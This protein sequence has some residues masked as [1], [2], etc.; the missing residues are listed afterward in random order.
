[1]HLDSYLAR[2]GYQGAVTPTLETLRKLHRAHLLA[3][4]FENLDIVP[5][6]RPISLELAATYH[7]IVEK[8]RGGFCFEQNGL[9]AWALQQLGFEVHL[10]Q[11]EV[12]HDDGGYGQPFNHLALLVHLEEAWLTD[13]GFGDHFIEPLRLDDP[14]AQH[15]A[16]GQFRIQHDGQAGF[17]E[18]LYGEE[19]RIDYRFFLTPRQLEDFGE[20]CHYMQTSPHTHFTQ[21]RV[22]SLLTPT[23]RL[24]LSNFTLIRTEQ[25]QRSETA[26]EGEAGFVAALKTHFGISL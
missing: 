17:L 4:P 11:A 8:R 2:I 24:T 5:L 9:F 19:W 26:L 15:D 13:V 25:G 1:M 14:Q 23:G 16:A 3:V 21:K 22:C 20:A 10:L 7:K 6:G 12:R 18:R